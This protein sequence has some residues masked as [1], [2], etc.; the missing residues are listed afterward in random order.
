MISTRLFLVDAVVLFAAALAGLVIYG[1]GEARAQSQGCTDVQAGKFAAA[2]SAGEQHVFSAVFASGEALSTSFSGGGG[3]TSGDYQYGG[4]LAKGGGDFYTFLP[5]N[6]RILAS[7]P[8]KIDT[9]TFDYGVSMGNVVFVDGFCVPTASTKKPVVAVVLPNGGPA[10]GGTTVLIDGTG[11]A[12]VTAVKFGNTNAT[13]FTLN[14]DRSISAMA[15]AGSG[16]VDITVTTSAGTSATGA[17]DTFTYGGTAGTAPT[18]TSVPPIVR[19]EGGTVFIA[20]TNFTGAT[21]VKFCGTDAL[22]FVVDSA[23]L[24]TATAPP[25]SGTV[26]V[27]VTTPGGTSAST[28][29]D[30]VTYTA[31]HDFGGIGEAGLLWQDTS[32]D[33]AIW[34]MNGTHVTSAVTLGK[35][36][37]TWSVVG[38]RDFNGDTFCDILWRDGSGNTAI[39]FVTP[40]TT[41]LQVSSTTSLGNVPISWSIAGTGD[42][43][44]DGYGDILWRDT[45][46]NTAIWFLTPGGTGVQVLSTASL[47]N[48]PIAFSVVG[49][50]DFN[51]DG[52]SDLLW[53]DSSGNAAI[54]L[55]NGGT[56]LSSAA[57]GNVSTTWSVVGTR[58][59]DGDGKA[60]I[61]WHDSSGNTA[62]WF[63]SG[64][65]VSSVG[66]LGNVPAPP[67]SIAASGDFNGDSFSDILWRD[68]SGNTAIWFLYGATVE[69]SLGMGQISTTWKL[70][71]GNAD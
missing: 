67:W 69:A 70:Q 22:S 24:I 34:L 45:S 37:G 66:S 6:M 52:K 39:W 55:L 9:G 62:I 26:D 65:Q 47:G 50:G 41:A 4:S 16:T 53:R 23:T 28:A 49:T 17:G 14:C 33:T 56:V 64:T 10:A 71:E 59:F 8:S 60:D 36:S 58:D 40:G 29:A 15:P 7:N 30:R 20:G 2:V 13:S 51:G 18:V 21:A 48:V 35:I 54:W 46:G 57:L 11:L 1:C 38:Q 68:T 32:G 19:S 27:T 63:V 44:G 42:F 25:G 43:N 5:P 3:D 61:L 31:N 12:G